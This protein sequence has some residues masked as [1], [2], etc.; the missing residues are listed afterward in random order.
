[1]TSLLQ[2]FGPVLIIAAFT[3]G[4]SCV[5]ATLRDR[6]EQA[7]IRRNDIRLIQ[8]IYKEGIRRTAILRSNREN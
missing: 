6:N 1:M 2:L 3:F 5:V 4:V 8:S 7:R